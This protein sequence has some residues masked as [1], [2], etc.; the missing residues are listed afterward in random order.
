M[1]H[2]KEKKEK[3]EQE[4]REKQEEEERRKNAPF[5]YFDINY[6]GDLEEFK[7]LLK[8][9]I[10]FDF[11]DMGNNTIYVKVKQE[12]YET[13]SLFIQA[14]QQKS[15]TIKKY[16]EISEEVYTGALLSLDKIIK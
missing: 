12:D 16:Q 7:K 9:K 4:K 13:F 10:G 5:R 6:Q 2:K 3:K 11:K 15:S 14:A 1:F 8:K